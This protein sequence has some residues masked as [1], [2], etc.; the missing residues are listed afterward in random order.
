[1]R[2]ACSTAVSF[3]TWFSLCL[4][5][6]YV[7]VF[8][9]LYIHTLPNPRRGADCLEIDVKMQ[10]MQHALLKMRSDGVLSGGYGRPMCINVSPKTDT[11]EP[12][13]F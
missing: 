5:V 7:H 9:W 6:Q 8:G 10:G 1:M 13:T 12:A 2:G 11:P 3:L 4:S